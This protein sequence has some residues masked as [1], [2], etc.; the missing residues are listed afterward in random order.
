MGIAPIGTPHNKSQSSLIKLYIASPI[1]CLLLY[2]IAR[3]FCKRYDV[4]PIMVK[5]MME[6]KD[7]DA[8]MP[9]TK[10]LEHN[11][12]QVDQTWQHNVRGE[13]DVMAIQFLQELHA[14]KLSPCLWEAYRRCQIWKD[15][16][17]N[18]HAWLLKLNDQPQFSSRTLNYFADIEAL[19]H[20]QEKTKLLLEQD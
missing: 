13:K 18:P 5:N 17:Y 9:C 14:G 8:S 3:W 15:A 4:S 12:A 16:V 6:I 11:Y 20:Q 19:H 2:H 7:F 10:E 1:V